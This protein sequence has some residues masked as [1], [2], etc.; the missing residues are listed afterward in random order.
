ML[1]FLT[2]NT[3]ETEHSFLCVLCLE[4]LRHL[5]MAAQF[6]IEKH[7]LTQQMTGQT[8]FQKSRHLPFRKQ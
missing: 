4:Y 3:Q 7:F 2:T 8:A 1:L 6:K 5:S